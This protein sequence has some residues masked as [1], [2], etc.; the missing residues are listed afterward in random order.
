MDLGWSSKTTTQ[1]EAHIHMEV[2][3][4]SPHW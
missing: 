3:Q 2:E 4:L 1:E